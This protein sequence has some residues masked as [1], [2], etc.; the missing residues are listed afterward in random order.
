MT[1]SIGM[2]WLNDYAAALQQANSQAIAQLFHPGLTYI[3]NDKR[4]EGSA[5]F[6][7]SIIWE[8]IFSKV[9]FSF[10]KAYNLMEVYSGCI[11]YHEVLKIR[12]KSNGEELE[13]HFGDQSVVNSDG[14]MLLINRIADPTYF[15]KFT[16][17]LT[18]N[19]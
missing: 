5:S 4:D 10:V 17:A 11:I 1:I 16:S 9:K 6:C 18:N 13:G 8:S 14:K 15:T 19:S 2:Q 7:N 3:V 12:I